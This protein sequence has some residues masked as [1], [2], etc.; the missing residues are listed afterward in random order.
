MLIVPVVCHMTLHYRCAMSIANSAKETHDVIA[1]PCRAETV[2]VDI[3][4]PL[5]VPRLR[6]ALS[7]CPSIEFKI[8][9]HI[10]LIDLLCYFKFD[11]KNLYLQSLHLIVA[12]FFFFSFFLAAS[13]SYNDESY[14][15]PVRQA[16]E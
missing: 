4:R 11:Y 1:F 15:F 8:Q 14:E 2:A 7:K 16:Q 3:G 9:F 6:W 13:W 10:A 5:Q 12:V